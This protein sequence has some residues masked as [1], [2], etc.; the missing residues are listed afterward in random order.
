MQIYMRN[1]SKIETYWNI[2]R[3]QAI[4]W[5]GWAWHCILFYSIQFHSNPFSWLTLRNRRIQIAFRNE[6]GFSTWHPMLMSMCRLFDTYSSHS[7]QYQMLNKLPRKHFLKLKYIQ[8][9]RR[10]KGIICWTRELD[11]RCV[12]R[13]PKDGEKIIWCKYN[14][15]LEDR[16]IGFITR[17][18]AYENRFGRKVPTSLKT[19]SWKVS[20]KL[21]SC[22]HN[23]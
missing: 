13:M 17:F 3:I 20:H 9:N 23:F 12:K 14:A 1:K 19:T 5:H 8:R 15:C 7:F 6:N 2:A 10:A 16:Q 11:E 21:I 22:I 4:L 18:K